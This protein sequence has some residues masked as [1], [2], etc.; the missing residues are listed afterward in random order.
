MF[1]HKIKKKSLIL[2][3]IIIDGLIEDNATVEVKCP[4]SVKD[5]E[6]LEQALLEKKVNF[7]RFCTL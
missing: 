1:T 5:Y 7:I 4:F 6:S 2:S 3:N